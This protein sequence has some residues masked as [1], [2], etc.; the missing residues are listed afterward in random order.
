ME[1]TPYFNDICGALSRKLENLKIVEEKKYF[2]L[3][4]SG[5]LTNSRWLSPRE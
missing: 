1:H 3:Q 5:I 4:S 2:T